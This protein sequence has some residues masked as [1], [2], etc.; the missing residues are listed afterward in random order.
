MPPT[1]TIRAATAHDLPLILGFIRELAEYE[2]L[3]HAVV[4]SEAE[5]GAAL[6]GAHPAAEVLLAF[7]AEAPVG[8]AVY[9]QNFSTFLGRA[10]IYL[11][12]VFVKPT[13]RG[14]GCGRALLTQIGRIAHARNCGRL[15]WSVLDW[16]EPAIEF[17]R[18]LGA[19]PMAEWTV[20]RLTSEG[21]AKLAQA[22]PPRAPSDA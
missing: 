15:E 12:D 10:G 2:K 5:L 20:F 13:W 11:E 6:F 14:R 4:A 1:F 17:Y 18:K 19:E 21:I 9:F 16:N 3:A 8:F 7:E 22:D